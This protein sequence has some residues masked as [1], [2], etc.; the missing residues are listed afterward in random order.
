MTTKKQK[1]A[2]GEARQAIN[3][4]ESRRSGLEAQKRS[5]DKLKNPVSVRR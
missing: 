4:E 1:R 5:K 3:R 2:M